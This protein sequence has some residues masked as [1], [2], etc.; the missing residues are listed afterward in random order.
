MES[1]SRAPATH[2]QHLFHTPDKLHR[3]IQNPS[4]EQR[5]CNFMPK[6]RDTPQPLS[7]AKLPS[8]NGY[9]QLPKK[10]KKKTLQKPAFAAMHSKRPFSETGAIIL[11][12]DR[13]SVFREDAFALAFAPYSPRL[14]LWPHVSAQ[15]ASALMTSCFKALFLRAADYACGPLQHAGSLVES[16]VHIHD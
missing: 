6:G 8:L 9:I 5:L 7:G 10:K 16:I 13:I 14:Y 2:I 12:T 15:T 4:A 3:S 11:K 1:L